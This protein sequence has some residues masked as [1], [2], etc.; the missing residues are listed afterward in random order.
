MQNS[1]N[2]R[3]VFTRPFFLFAPFAGH[4]SSSPFLGTFSPFS[5]PRK[6]LCSVEKR[7]QRRAWRGAAVGC[8]SPQSSGRK[9]LPEICLKKGQI[10]S[11]KTVLWKQYSARFLILE[12]LPLSHNSS[13]SERIDL[14]ID[15]CQNYGSECKS[16]I[17]GATHSQG[18][19][20]GVTTLL[21]FAKCSRPFIQSVES[22]LSYLRS[23]RPVRGAPR[24]TPLDT[25]THVHVG[26]TTQGSYQNVTE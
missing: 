19:P 5:P 20:E 17:R 21:H 3:L 25:L 8:T 24:E 14:R 4:P 2:S 9:F 15:L 11:S 26:A 7:V 13:Q 18:A 22:T 6:V 23:C 12:I 1:V 16:K 10:L